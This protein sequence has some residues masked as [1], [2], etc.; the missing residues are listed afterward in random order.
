MDLRQVAS[1]RGRH[2]GRE[3]SLVWTR[4]RTNEHAKRVLG[5][6]RKLLLQLHLNTDAL[7]RRTVVRVLNTERNG[8]NAVSSR[9]VV[10]VET[11]GGRLEVRLRSRDP[12]DVSRQ[13]LLPTDHR[14]TVRESQHPRTP[15]IAASKQAARTVSAKIEEVSV[16]CDITRY[17]LA[18]SRPRPTALV[19]QQRRTASLMQPQEAATAWNSSH[20][21]R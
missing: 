2:V 3:T 17:R 12:T 8:W 15:S 18:Q 21:S 1:Q 16:R 13:P 19:Q 5:E 9:L 7:T 4:R 14:R 20:S 6:Q 11:G 10:L